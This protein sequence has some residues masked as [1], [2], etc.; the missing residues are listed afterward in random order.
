[1]LLFLIINQSIKLDKLIIIKFFKFRNSKLSNNNG[2]ATLRDLQ[3]KHTTGIREKLLN[4]TIKHIT[5]AA[6]AHINM[7]CRKNE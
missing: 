3:H 4:K 1:M 7:P 5:I 6:K 2:L